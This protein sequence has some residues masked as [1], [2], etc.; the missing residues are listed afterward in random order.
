MRDRTGIAVRFL[1]WPL[2][3]SCAQ[4]PAKKTIKHH[5]VIV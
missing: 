3:I 2:S 1:R 4:G 5:Y